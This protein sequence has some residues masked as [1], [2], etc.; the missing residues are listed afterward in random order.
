[1]GRELHMDSVNK[2]VVCI[3]AAGRGTRVGGIFHKAL[4][5]I[6]GKAVISHIIEKWPVDTEY[7]IAVGY[8]AQELYEYVR[9]AHYDR[10]I[11]FVYVDNYEGPNSGP[12][13]SLFECRRYLQKSFYLTTSDCLVEHDIPSIDYNWIGVAEVDNPEKWATV[14][15]DEDDRVIG[16][17][18]KDVAGT[19][20]GYIGLAAVRDYEQFWRGFTDYVLKGGTENIEGFKFL[21]DVY[22]IEFD[23][24]DTGT[25]E[26][27]AAARG[28]KEYL[29]KTHEIT[30]RVNGQCVKLST[31]AYMKALRNH[32]VK[33]TPKYS[34]AGQ[35]VVAYPWIF[36]KTYYELADKASALSLLNDCQDAIWSIIGPKTEEFKLNCEKFYKDKTLERVQLFLDLTTFNPQVINGEKYRPLDYYLNKVNWGRYINLAIPCLFHGDFNFGNI[37]RNEVFGN[38]LIDLRDSFNGSIYGDAYYDLAK[39]YAGLLISWEDIKQGKF[40]LTELKDGSVYFR[41]DNKLN[42]I[43]REYE[44]WLIK[45]GYDVNHVVEMALVTILNMTPIH[46]VDLGKF[47]MSF[48]IVELDKFYK[49]RE[50]DIS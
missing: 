6:N 12:G 3:L 31:N 39:F 22:T 28:E 14:D 38:Y 42:E 21:D 1:M 11:D 49:L 23:W 47:L 33:F 4:L 37:V 20:N 35:K 25:L 19:T 24:K 5:P 44:L 13:V 48:A 10:K 40:I 32:L 50:H 9:A 8:Q 18:N 2:E 46:E 45:N 34:Y 17:C 27:Y 26:N 15:I 30:Y 41:Y 7:V 43:R 16:W 36:G 29:G